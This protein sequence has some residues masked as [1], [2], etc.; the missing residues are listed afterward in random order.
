M[1]AGDYEG[2]SFTEEVLTHQPVGAAQLPLRAVTFAP[3]AGG[4][5]LAVKPASF[6]VTGQLSQVTLEVRDRLGRNYLMRS[7]GNCRSGA[8]CRLAWSETLR[9]KLKLNS[10]D[11]WPLAFQQGGLGRGAYFPVCFCDAA[12]DQP[13]PVEATFVPLKS[14][15]VA[16]R[17]YGVGERLLL[18]DEQEVAAGLPWTI[19]FAPR[20]GESVRI[21]VDHVAAEGGRVDRF[22]DV[23]VVETPS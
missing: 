19:R 2:A 23:F 1:S 7:K 3:R 20:R 17:V 14:L 4:P 21:V 22:T 12:A 13:R 16:V 15:S 5:P 6:Y 8:P 11:L 18:Q 10:A 9:A